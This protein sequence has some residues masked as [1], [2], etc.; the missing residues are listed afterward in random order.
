V[1]DDLPRVV[2]HGR[3]QLATNPMDAND[4]ALLYDAR[5]TIGEF[6]LDAILIEIRAFFS[7]NS[8]ATL[9]VPYTP[10]GATAF[11]AHKPKLME[12]TECDDFDQEAAF[13]AFFQGVDSH[14]EGKKIWDAALDQ[15]I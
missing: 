2:A 5:I 8:A 4:A 1:S 3:E 9:A 11:R 13:S 10:K 6:K 15:S 14:E 7:P 12:W